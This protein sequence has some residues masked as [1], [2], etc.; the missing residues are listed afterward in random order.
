MN[1]GD[2]VLKR[3]ATG[4][5]PLEK[6]AELG[7]LPEELSTG[8]IA[9]LWAMGDRNVLAPLHEAI[10]KAVEMDHLKGKKFPVWATKVRS[11]WVESMLG[12]SSSPTHMPTGYRIMIHKDDFL[13]WLQT[14]GESIPPNNLLAKWIQVKTIYP[15]Q[16]Q[17]LYEETLKGFKAAGKTLAQIDLKDFLKK[18]A[19]LVEE[20]PDKYTRISKEFLLIDRWN[21]VWSSSNQRKS[22]LKTLSAMLDAS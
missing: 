20:Y 6:A 14:I 8:Q 18:A 3:Y 7:S 15:E 4:S 16:V 9:Y 22:F 11:Q 13:D 5:L 17:L 1:P 21:H 12:P 2:K 19:I 10:L